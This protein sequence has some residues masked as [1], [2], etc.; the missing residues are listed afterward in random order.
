MPRIAR[1]HY[2]LMFHDGEVR[3]ESRVAS[4]ERECVNKSM[5][6]KMDH[7][8]SGAGHLH[9]FGGMMPAAAK[10]ASQRDQTNFHAYG[11]RKFCNV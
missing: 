3:A 7:R 10:R 1:M 2:T 9:L 8:R 5:A 11:F 6:R 4:T